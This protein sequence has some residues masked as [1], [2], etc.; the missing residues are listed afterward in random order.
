MNSFKDDDI[1]VVGIYCDYKEFN[2]Q[3]TS[4]YLASLLQR[5]I[6]QRAS[7][8]DQIKNAY[9]AHSRKQTAPSFPEYLD[10]LQG[11][12]QAFTRVYI[13]IDALDECTEANGVR[14][15]F[16]ECHD[17]VPLHTR[18]RRVFP[19]CPPTRY[20][21]PRRRHTSPCSKSTGQGENLGS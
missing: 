8:P 2:Q 12:M 20:K 16:Y 10:L 15:D 17:H 7:I 9:V 5:L 18:Y 11:Q 14:E 3:S 1:A 13:I 21:C 19:R 6:I 4:K